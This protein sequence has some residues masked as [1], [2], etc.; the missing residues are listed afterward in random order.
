MSKM[1]HSSIR[2]GRGESGKNYC[3]VFIWRY[4]LSH[5][6]RL[7][8]IKDVDINIKGNFKVRKQRIV[9]SPTKERKMQHKKILNPKEK[10]RKRKRKEGTKNRWDK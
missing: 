6:G 5:E 10:K 4:I 2:A 1:S 7:L 3:K 9:N 8:W